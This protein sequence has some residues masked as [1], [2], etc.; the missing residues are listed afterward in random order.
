M[1]VNLFSYLIAVLAGSASPVQAGASAQLN[2]D[3]ASPIW[4]ALCVYASGLAGVVIVQLILRE[5]WPAPRLMG[6]AHWWAWT[7]GILSIALTMTGLTL[8]HKM[9]SGL[10]TGLTL[11]ASLLTSVLL[12]QFGLMGFDRHPVTA[13]RGLGAGLMIA[14]IWLIAKF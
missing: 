14:G 13:L 2:K 11:T 7:G 6:G 1:Y 10:Y 4:A 9:G 3:L 5:A 8:A 12:D